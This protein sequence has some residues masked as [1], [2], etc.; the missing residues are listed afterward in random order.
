VQIFEF[1]Y[2]IIVRIPFWA[3][4]SIPFFIGLY[5]FAKYRRGLKIRPLFKT[6]LFA[7]V[8]T[9]LL[10][11]APATMF[12]ALLPNGLLLLLFDGGFYIENWDWFAVSISISA[13]PI[14]VIAQKYLRAT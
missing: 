11:P 7:F 4:L 14:F 8:A 13:I 6:T 2:Q 10:A 1:I 12:I 3:I 5:Y 9:I